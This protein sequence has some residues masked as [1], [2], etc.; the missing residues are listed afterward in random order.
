MEDDK[1]EKV[2][3]AAKNQIKNLILSKKTG[4]VELILELNFSQGGIGSA[5]CS[6]NSRETICFKRDQ[7]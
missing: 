2:L 6:T 3:D 4:K 7:N 5:F 1:V